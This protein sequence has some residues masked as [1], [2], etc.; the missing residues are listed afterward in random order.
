MI[1]SVNDHLFYFILL[2]SFQVNILAPIIYLLICGFLVI[3]SCYKTPM[4]VGIGTAII[5][6]GIPIYYCTIHKPNP[7]LTRM[8]AKLNI[9]C[10]KLFLC[11]PNQEKF[12]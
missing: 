2:Y 4:E 7:F 11:M 9:F 8:S 10:A 3:S 12:D 6:T 5:L 1:Y